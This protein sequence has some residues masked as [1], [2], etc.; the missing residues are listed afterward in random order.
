MDGIGIRWYP[1][2]CFFDTQMSLAPKL[3]I[4]VCMVGV[5]CLFV[6]YASKV[7]TT[8]NFI[9]ISVYHPCILNYT[10]MWYNYCI[11]CTKLRDKD[12]DGF[13]WIII[14]II[15]SNLPSPKNMK[16]RMDFPLARTPNTPSSMIKITMDFDESSSLQGS[17]CKED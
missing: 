6:K 1:V 11:T 5:I 9:L 10:Y 4:F 15:H 14:I 2:L 7:T 3:W 17:R 16:I 13:W 8:N 12:D